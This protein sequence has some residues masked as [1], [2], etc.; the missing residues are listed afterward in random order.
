MLL[1]RKHARDAG[2]IGRD[3]TLRA[4]A[5]R[6]AGQWQTAALLYSE[7]AR[8]LPNS[9]NLR[10]QAG[11][12]FKESGIHEEA[13]AHY[14]AAAAMA[15]HDAD[16]ALQIGHF[17]KSSGRPALAAEAYG[18]ALTLKP[19]WDEARNELAALGASGWRAV[20]ER[21]APTSLASD[22]PL[23]ELV[24]RPHEDLLV[25][26]QEGVEMRRLGRRER[27]R[28]GIE[29]TLRGV[30]AIRGFC[31]SLRPVTEVQ[32]YLN[33]QLIHRGMVKGGYLLKHERSDLGPRKYVFN[34]WYDF[35]SYV[36]GWHDIEV[37][38][39]DGRSRPLS[40]HTRIVID[41][42]LSE[43]AHAAS[44]GVVEVAVGDDR[45]IEQQIRSRRSMVREGRR[46]M[47][48]TPPQTILVQRADQLGDVVV[49]VPA[50]RR[51]RALFP[52]A[53][54][55]GLVSSANRDLVE[56]LELF[57]ECLPIDFPDDLWERR[58]VM[59]IEAQR[60][61]Q[62][63]LAAYNF[64]MAID[65]SENASSRPLLLLSAAPVLV[66]FRSD[67]VPSLTIEIEGNTHDRWDGHEIVPHTN[68][69]LGLVEWLGAMARSETNIVRRKNLSRERL[70]AFNLL[71][72]ERF[73]VLH[74][75][76]RL[77][78][79]RWPHYLRLA[80]QILAKTDVR[81][82]MLTDDPVD[83]SS[84]PE[85][86]LASGRFELIDRRLPFDDF[87]A[88]LSFASVFVGN[89]S[90]PKHIASLRGTQ[91]VSIH[92]ARNNWNEWGQENGGLIVS[93]RV[94]CTGCLVWHDPEECGKDFACITDIAPEEVAR[95]VYRLL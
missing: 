62:R 31:I 30:E 67:R 6:D 84:L 15:P 94:P 3:M 76:A 7:A 5:A 61:L 32:L 19:K 36:P 75:G 47:F 18:R 10:I 27:T 70:A 82:V 80:E 54:I 14:K 58:R 17:Y 53:R 86:L 23:L 91:V 49:S 24:P 60:T 63:Q 9:A 34:I 68:K 41:E 28:W 89:D 22:V 33:G 88:L 71:E 64:D 66:G 48:A 65:F 1:R 45:T 81:V 25:D 87:D 11:H 78:F 56:T 77:K 13:E 79:S 40:H 59:G 43:R 57:D 4:D 29:T 8:L 73:V 39:M 52:E 38:L 55:V 69:L 93:R 26:H 42:P 46:A 16:L 90:G 92:M 12:M 37:R 2:E 51:L 85:S 95:A 50:M 74:D 35:S 83:Q 20:R 21:H 44:D 72:T